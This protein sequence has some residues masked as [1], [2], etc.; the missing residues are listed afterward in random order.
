MKKASRYGTHQ[1]FVV[2]SPMKITRPTEG[3]ELTLC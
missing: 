3:F 2:V 1:C